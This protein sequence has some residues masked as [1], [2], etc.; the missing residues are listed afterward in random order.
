VRQLCGILLLLAGV[1]TATAATISAQ[2]IDR[3]QYLVQVPLG[4]PRL[5]PQTSASAALDLFGD[6]SD[7]DYVDRDPVDGID[8]RR[9]GVLMGLA[10]RFAPYLVLNTTNVPVGFSTYARNRDDFALHIDHWELTD[11]GPVRVGDSGVN[12][13]I[14]GTATCDPDLRGRAFDSYP[15]PTD[16]PAIEDCK[17]L[18]LMDRYTPGSGAV[19]SLETSQVRTVPESQDVL[20][21]DFPGEG[22]GSW[23][24]GYVPEYERTP[25]ERR[26][27]FVEALV[28]PFIRELS[29]DGAY[30]LILQYWFFYPSNDSGMDHEGDWEHLNVVVSPRS[31]VERGMS[32][33]E[34]R[35]VL[36]GR[37]PATDDAAD[38]IVIKRLDYYFHNSVL[39]LDFARPNAYL[40]RDEW[41][42]QKRSLEQN[43][44]RQ[45]ELWDRIRYMAYAD[46]AESIVNTHPL[47][48]IGSDNKG[49]NQA[50]ELPGPRNRDAHGTYPI[51]GRYSNVGPG[52]TTDHLSH[53][54]DIRQVL[55][56]L[57]SG[58]IDEGPHFRGGTIVGFTD[59]ARLRIVPDWERV[60]EPA[61]ES[62]EVRAAWAWLV[63]PIKWGYPAT[64]SPLAGVIEHYNTGNNS[65]PGP[66]FQGS[67]NASG[68]APGV[69]AYDPHTL[70][71]LLPLQ[72]QDNF[73]NDLGFLNLTVPVLLNLPPLDFVARLLA[74]PVRAV[75]GRP[76][77]VFYPNESVPYRFLGLSSGLSVQW[78]S[79]DF[80]A[81]ALNP[82][83]LD[84]FTGSFLVHLIANG[85]DS[86]TTLVGGTDDRDVAV[87]SFAQL[88]FFIGN[89]FASENLVRNVRSGIHVRATF[90]NIPDYTYDA[91]INYWEYAGS[92]RYSFTSSRLQPYVKGGYGWAWYRLEN[93][94]IV[95]DLLDPP[96]S[97]WIGPSNVLPNV[98]H[99]GL[100]LEYVPSRRVGLIPGGLEVAFRLEYGRYTQAL[101]LDLS[102]IPLEDLS[103]LFPTLGDVPSEGTRVHRDDLMLGVSLTF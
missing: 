34:V 64:S 89:R 56:D 23:E 50:I 47:G 86:T 28:H 43:R 76:E 44:F 8:D 37:M 98:W 24:A 27:A 85:A 3:D 78:L 97:P 93:V 71:D 46:D 70:P 25:A 30:E 100:G 81:L 45:A 77:P 73:R 6:P 88:T 69:T 103:L 61:R 19:R 48:Y 36:E 5:T 79:E 101:G 15:E 67:W 52:G 2:E 59:P 16:D 95:G 96:D 94:S 72:I 66:S 74:Y 20:F 92:L 14:L 1:Q 99:Y 32:A 4:V 60:V 58:E 7:P 75:L 68:P 21:F 54:A 9:Q 39:Q 55:R 41:Q 49:L 38:P 63:L 40:P 91:D 90:T 42:A 51:P 65:P 17:L 62:A 26:N 29:T 83:Q 12:F 53:H 87:G 57:R 84:E 102:D 31:M 33:S 22:P 82:E 10:R 18:E 11:H 13:S 35:D 80:D